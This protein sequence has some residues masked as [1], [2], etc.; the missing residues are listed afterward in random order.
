[1]GLLQLPLFAHCPLT[2]IKQ[3]LQIRPILPSF[4]HFDYNFREIRLVT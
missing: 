4:L 1:M 3:R 2:R